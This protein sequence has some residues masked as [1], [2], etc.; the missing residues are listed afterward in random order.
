MAEGQCKQSPRIVEN[1]VVNHA[2]AGHPAAPAQRDV[3]SQVHVSL[4]KI[5]KS[6]I[7][8]QKDDCCLLTF[9]KKL[10]LYFYKSVTGCRLAR[11]YG[12]PKSTKTNI[13]GRRLKSNN[14]RASDEPETNRIR[15]SLRRSPQNQQTKG[16]RIMNT[17]TPEEPRTKNQ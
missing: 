16:A 12:R 1:A 5:K 8:P 10:L 9:I 4:S 7:H 3:V 17:S 13:G 11:L 15:D 2:G 14:T 6:H